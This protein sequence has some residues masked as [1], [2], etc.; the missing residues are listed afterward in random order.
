MAI[1]RPFI[2][3]ENWA[4]AHSVRIWKLEKSSTYFYFSILSGYSQQFSMKIWYLFFAL[5]LWQQKI[6]KLHFSSCYWFLASYFHFLFPPYNSSPMTS[7]TKSWRDHTLLLP[8][9]ASQSLAFPF[10]CHLLLWKPCLWHELEAC[11]FFRHQ[12]IAWICSSC[13]LW[14]HSLVK[15]EAV[16]NDASCILFSRVI[17]HHRQLL[18]FWWNQINFTPA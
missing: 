13:L 9:P 7:S 6:P 1:L 14:L 15:W 10:S 5:L 3:F 11:H 12:I 18:K 16:S 2:S 4:K 17:N 8:F